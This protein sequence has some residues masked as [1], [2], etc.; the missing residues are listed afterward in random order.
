MHRE[1][2]KPVVFNQ[3]AGGK[4]PSYY[5]RD[6]EESGVSIVIYS[7]PCLF[8]AQSSKENA[9]KSILD[10]EGHLPE[11]GKGGVDIKSCNA[12]LESNLLRRD[13]RQRDQLDL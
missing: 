8:S 4:S 12:L 7:T 11:E 5:F 3:I 2:G 6:L 13:R 1:T 10:N 9:L